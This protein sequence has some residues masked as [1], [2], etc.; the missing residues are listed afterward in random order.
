MFAEK[1]KTLGRRFSMMNADVIQ[2]KSAVICV[3]E[4]LA[5]AVSCWEERPGLSRYLQNQ[6]R[7]TGSHWD[8]FWYS[9]F[10]HARP[11]A[12]EVR[13]PPS[14]I[15]NYPALSLRKPTLTSN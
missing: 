4:A 2:R 14:L 9:A 5:A 3:Q 6:D 10:E 12:S 11:E 15:L 13:H 7:I 1:P 8:E